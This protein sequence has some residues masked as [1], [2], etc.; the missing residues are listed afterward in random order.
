MFA[1][2]VPASTIDLELQGIAS[3]LPRDEYPRI[4]DAGC[5]FGRI[6][7]P[8]SLLGYRVTGVDVNVEALRAA[9]SRAPG[10]SYVALDQRH[11]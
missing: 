7:G 4:L 6:A 10:P 11:V 2:T 8:L 5:G 3:V 9:N 1:A